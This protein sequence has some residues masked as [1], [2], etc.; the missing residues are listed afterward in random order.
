[1]AQR[2]E[3]RASDADRER[4]GERLR[5]ATAEGR[6]AAHELEHRL[7]KAL[8]ARTYGELDDVVADLPGKRVAPKHGRS[9]RSVPLPA[10]FIAAIAMVLVVAVALA[11]ILSVAALWMVWMVIAWGMFGRRGRM[12]AGPWGP[13]G[14]SGRHRSLAH[15]PERHL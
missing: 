5:Q 13:R 4:I 14:M 12:V 6:L 8:R 10:L 9:L 1:M 15:Q 2:R 7:A 11:V 3:L